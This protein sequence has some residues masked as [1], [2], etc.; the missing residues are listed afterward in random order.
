MNTLD[1]LQFEA[2]FITL[3]REKNLKKRAQ[4]A[5]SFWNELISTTSTPLVVG[6]RAYFLY[7]GDAQ[8]VGLAGDW[9]RWRPAAELTRVPKTKL[10][11]KMLEFPET[12]RLQYKLIIDGNWG[13]D[14]HNSHYSEEGFGINSEFLMPQ[15][16]DESW[17][18]PSPELLK[19]LQAS[20]PNEDGFVEIEPQKKGKLERFFVE[21]KVLKEEREIFLYTP[22]FKTGD[23]VKS[24]PLLV[25]HDGSEAVTIGKYDEILNNLI[26]AG[27]LRPCLALFISPKMR[28]A[29]YALN[30]AFVEFCV[31]EAMSFAVKTWRERG[32]DVSCDPHERCVTGASLG[33]LLATNTIFKNPDVLGA[34]IVQ[35][36]AYWW[37][38]RE[39]FKKQYFKHASKLR[40]VLQT[41]TVWDTHL[42]A[43]AMYA[44]LKERGAE[45]FYQEFHQGHTWGNWRTNF[46]SGV[47]AWLPKERVPSNRKKCELIFDDEELISI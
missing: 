17:L 5:E 24:L 41:G 21:S 18:S 35:S 27:E 22:A 23:D 19:A 1:N 9:S 44:A 39:I 26:A 32:L 25:I 30:D 36:P 11:F 40:V 8:T 15:Y 34:A 37:Q 4:L 10:F 13:M 3:V 45:V 14:V 20:Q 33:G 38:K 2:K 29:E 43:V 16:V 31:K 28:N 42:N 12:A 7:F 6:N 47:R 46:A